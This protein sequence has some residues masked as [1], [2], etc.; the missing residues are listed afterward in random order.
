MRRAPFGGGHARERRVI[1][2]DRARRRLVHLRQQLHQRRLARAVFADDGDHRA[3]RQGDGHVVEHEARRAGIGER[4]AIEADAVPQPRGHGHVRRGVERRRVVFEPREAARAIHP[5]AAQETD[6]ADGG[7]DVGGEARARRDDQQH[8]GC[9]RGEVR[10]DEDDG[11]DVADAE[12]GPAERVPQR[13]GP[14][15]GGDGR[16]GAFERLAALRHQ[17]RADAGDAHFLGRRRS[18]RRG[19]QMTREAHRLRGAFVRDAF[20]GGPP[21]GRPHGGNRED[22]DENQ[23]GVNGDEQRDRDAEPQNPPQVENSDMYM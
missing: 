10:R 22:G 19:E 6:L 16:V 2:L 8:I 14:A 3:F 4:H 5:E 15:R 21:G 23:R 17:A 1:N 7:A 12:D 18:G 13:G 9:R 20:D 11:A